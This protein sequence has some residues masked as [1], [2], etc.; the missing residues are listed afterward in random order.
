[1]KNF[2]NIYL[3][4]Q[5]RWKFIEYIWL[6]RKGENLSKHFLSKKR[7][8]NGQNIALFFSKKDDLDSP[9]NYKG[10]T[11]TATAA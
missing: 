9:S 1:M 4:Y 10:I 7:L 2:L 8:K 6:I 5:K 11:L 3:T